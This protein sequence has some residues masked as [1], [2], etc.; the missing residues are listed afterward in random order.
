[1]SLGSPRTVASSCRHQTPAVPTWS[2]S[3]DVI[4][5]ALRRGDTSRRRLCARDQRFRS[6]KIGREICL[7]WR[8]RRA[9]LRL[10]AAE[11]EGAFRLLSNRRMLAVLDRFGDVDHASHLL[12]PPLLAE[13]RLLKF[14]PKTLGYAFA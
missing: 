10:S 14:A 2:T 4:S 1:M 7:G 8:L 13:P 5:D 9:F 6:S 12:A 11:I 3:G